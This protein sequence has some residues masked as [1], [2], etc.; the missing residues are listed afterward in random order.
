MIIHAA[1]HLLADGDL[2][3]GL[4]NLWDIDRLL[5]E[6]C[7][8]E[9]DFVLHLVEEAYSHGLGPVVT[10]ALRLSQQIFG[11]P[12][13]SYVTPSRIDHARRPSDSLLRKRLL[14]RNGWG[15]GAR[16]ATRLGFYV[17]SHWL[18]MP[19]LMLARHLWIKARR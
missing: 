3:G 7:R 11:T 18:R 13:K 17:R 19:P 6:F 15:Q 8:A 4:R 14:A 10:A 12:L 16:P 9:D 5:R 1:A 2:S